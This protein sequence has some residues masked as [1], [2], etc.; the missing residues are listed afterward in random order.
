MGN[1]ALLSDVKTLLQINQSDSSTDAI[2]SLLISAVSTQIESYC[3][4]SFGVADYIENIPPSNSQ[5]LQLQNWPINTVAYV[6]DQGSILTPGADYSVYPQFSK[7]GQIYRPQGWYGLMAVRGLTYDPYASLITLEVSYNAGYLLPGATPITGV[8]PLPNDLQLC[9]QIMVAKVYELSNNGN[10]GEN[11][12]SVK[13]GGLAYAWDNPAKIPPDLFQVI[14]GM[15]VQF[16][17]L[18]NPYKRWVSA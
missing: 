8:L 9:C 2:L 15:P 12:A 6:K 17:Q 7:C 10:L 1:L 14:S 16:A 3:A 11:L 5:Q 4:R 18:L 13:E